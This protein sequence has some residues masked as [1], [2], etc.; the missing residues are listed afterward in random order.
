MKTFDRS[1]FGTLT[2]LALLAV[3]AAARAQ[4]AAVPP[5]AAAPPPAAEAPAPPP[6]AEETPPAPPTA[7]AAPPAPPPPV[8]SQPPAY[9]AP[10]AYGA[11]PA[12]AP[13]PSYAPAPA[14]PPA[15]A[16]PPGY[17]QAPY[18]PPPAYPP[19]GGYP[20]PPAGSNAQEEPAHQGFYLRLHMGASDA[21]FTGNNNRTGQK[22]EYSGGGISFGVSIGGAVAPGFILFGEILAI[23]SDANNLTLDGLSAGTRNATSGLGGFG[24]GGLYYFQPVNLYLSAALT[25]LDSSVTDNDTNQTLYQSNVGLGFQGMIG[26]EWWV[27]R[28]WGIGGAAEVLVSSMKD[29]N[30]SD[31]TWTATAFSLVFSATYN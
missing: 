16:P 5:T 6:P 23:G 2:A 11:P 24:F 27:T 19:P 13:A 12:Y 15:Y 9:P 14:Y 21:S 28:H 26:K 7:P 1:L 8:Y 29:K 18:Y 20:Y 4:A 22:L 17:R 31:L 30:D 3:P 10:P 25:F